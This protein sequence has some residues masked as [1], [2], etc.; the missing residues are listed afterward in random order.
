MQKPKPRAR[1]SPDRA[2]AILIASLL[3]M[4]ALVAAWWSRSEPSDGLRI[5]GT[6]RLTNASDLPTAPPMTVALPERVPAGDTNHNMAPAAP[7]A[8]STTGSPPPVG[9]RGQVVRRRDGAPFDGAVVQLHA[10]APLA[11]PLEP[12]LAAG[13]A[14][15][16]ATRSDAAGRFHFDATPVLADA[17]WLLA[18]ADGCAAACLSLARGA[19]QEWRIELDEGRRLRGRVVGA[20]DGRLLAG[21]RV[22]VFL[23]GASA[24]E[25]AHAES[26]GTGGFEFDG[27]PAEVVGLACVPPGRWRSAGQRCD[28]RGGDRLAERIALPAGG[29]V[30]GRV[31]EVAGRPVAGARVAEGFAG[32]KQVATDVEGRFRLEGVAIGAIELFV[33][34]EGTALAQRRVVVPADGSPANVEVVLE[35]GRSV[36]GRVVDAA[37]APV[38]GASVVAEAAGFVGGRQQLDLVRGATAADGAFELAGLRAD[39]RHRLLVAARGCA[40]LDFALPGEEGTTADGGPA[41]LDVGERVMAAESVLEVRRRFG[42]GAPA[43]G[44]P[45]TLLREPTPDAPPPRPR[46]ATTDADGSARF[47]RL[48]VAAYRVLDDERQ[49]P[50]S[51]QRVVIAAA[52]EQLVVEGPAVDHALID[53]TVELPDG[54]PAADVCVEAFAADGARIAVARSDHDGRFRLRPLEARGS[55][56]AL[57]ALAG[58]GPAPRVAALPSEVSEFTAA[59]AP[60]RLRLRAG[61][62]T[63]GRVLDAAG[64]PLAGA[65][66]ARFAPDAAHPRGIGGVSFSADGDGHFWCLLAPGEACDV[67]AFARPASAAAAGEGALRSAALRLSGASS[68]EAILTASPAEV[69]ETGE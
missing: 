35:A 27:L 44:L 53:G 45:I 51:G 59:G 7:V 61:Q 18:T 13:V 56:Q 37:G 8:E 28:L 12:L 54:G 9:W 23:G 48:T 46:F 21:V 62:T 20:E 15:L 33:R 17:G 30:R 60:L 3:A 38:A 55:V 31:R 69:Q 1:L 49:R 19:E 57:P 14:P 22:S 32:G 29:E 47:D 5:V 63:R 52:G 4:A 40:T 26:D 2:F 39:L 11:S 50:A 65:L 24:R 66:L 36:R 67:I 68:G 25:L 58:A 6:A 10:A 43:A 16:G 34:Q 42:D 41:P 64:Q